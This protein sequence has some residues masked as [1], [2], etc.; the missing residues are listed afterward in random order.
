MIRLATP[1]DTNKIAGFWYRYMNKNVNKLRFDIAGFRKLID[2]GVSSAKHFCAIDEEEG[3][4]NGVIFVSVESFPWAE[5]NYAQIQILK[6]VKAE[7]L[8]TLFYNWYEGRRAIVAIGYS[9][10]IYSKTDLIL[11]KQGFNSTGSMLIK[12]RYGVA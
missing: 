12:F 7:E 1:H 6:G 5:K 8:Y 11:K 2:I 9:S 4:V 3:D 10:L